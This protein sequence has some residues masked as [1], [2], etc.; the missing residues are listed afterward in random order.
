M[1]YSVFNKHAEDFY[2][3]FYKQGRITVAGI[4]KTLQN[5]I[6]FFRNSLQIMIV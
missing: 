4:K 3:V 2:S 1:V 5:D 6:N